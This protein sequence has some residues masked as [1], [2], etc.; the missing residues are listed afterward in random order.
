MLVALNVHPR[1]LA[2]VASFVF[3]SFCAPVVLCSRGPVLPSSP[4]TQPADKWLA[5]D[6]AK[7]FSACAVIESV[8]YGIASA[9]Q[10][11]SASLRIGGAAVL[12]VGLGRELYDWRVKGHF[13]L[14]DL[15]WDAIGGAAAALA[16]HAVR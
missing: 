5:L 1:P 11:H 15:A 16:L 14:K 8:G 4:F 12:A 9:H 13:S 7:H 10:G 3:P 2:P 6:K